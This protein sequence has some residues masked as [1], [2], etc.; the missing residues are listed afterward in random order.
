MQTCAPKR[1]VASVLES[2]P[3]PK[4][5]TLRSKF[6]G[7]SRRGAARC[8]PLLLDAVEGAERA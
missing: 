4:A 8:C 6:T 2:G 5:E 7:G 1:H 3:S